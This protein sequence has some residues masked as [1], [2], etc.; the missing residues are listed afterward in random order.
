MFAGADMFVARNIDMVLLA[1]IARLTLPTRP[2]IVYECLDI[3]ALMTAAG[4]KAT[5]ARWIERRM[6]A[7]TALLVLS[8]P[9]FATHYFQARQGYS[10]RWFLLENKLWFPADPLPRPQAPTPRLSGA[11]LV[12]GWVGAIRCAPSLDILLAAAAAAPDRLQI[13]IHGVIH[14]HA[15]PDFDARIAALPNVT[16]AG[17][18]SYPEG[19]GAIYDGCDLVWAQDLWQ[20]GANSDWLLPNR[21]Y[22]ASWFGCPSIAVAGTQTA[23]RIA[24]DGL[25]IVLPTADADALLAALD[26]LTPAALDRLRRSV[27]ACP[28]TALA[29]SPADV[30][31]LVAATL[32][33]RAMA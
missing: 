31:A 9:G 29:Q 16:Y 22:E 20:R 10:G 21:I 17:P 18:Y 7:R 25:G 23:A 13:R 5:L 1:W 2:P 32:P 6:L 15:L 26:A 27:L 14:R 8:S 19:L 33:A 12:L 11:R 4:A 3:H 28:E 30:D 24:A